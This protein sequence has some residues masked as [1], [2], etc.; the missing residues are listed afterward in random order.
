M[1]HFQTKPIEEKR[2]IMTPA[3]LPD[4]PRIGV[5]GLG[6]VA[7]SYTH[8]S[9]LEFCREHPLESTITNE[10]PKTAVQ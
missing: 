2:A 6:Y 1:I 8:L 5:I 7:V 9:I 3:E 4:N 10:V